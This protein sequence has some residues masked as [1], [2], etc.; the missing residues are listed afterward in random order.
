MRMIRRRYR[1]RRPRR[2]LPVWAIVAIVAGAV[3]IAALVTG[4]ILNSCLDDDTYK[5]LTDGETD[6]KEPEEEP[7]TR[8]SPSVH[9]YPFRLGESL[10]GLGTEPPQALI[11]PLKDADGRMCY[12]SP[13]TDYLGL[14][15]AEGA[16]SNAGASMTALTERVPYLI[17]VWQVSLP[18]DATDAVIHAA[19][20]TDAAVM[21]E[22]LSMGGS[23]LLLRGL[24][25]TEDTFEGTYAYLT[26]LREALGA[27]TVLSVAVPLSVAAGDFG[28]DVLYALSQKTSHLTLDL[29]A[30]ED[31]GTAREPETESGTE[32]E[33]TSGDPAE[34][35]PDSPL[36]RAAF[37]LSGY[38][39]RLL[40]GEA[41]TNLILSAEETIS[42]FAILPQ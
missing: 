21:R 15:T 10:R 38:R 1:P 28:V 42:D 41:Q 22:F 6:T 3:L 16:A 19:A 8:T 14:E 2:A 11:L 29:T 39:M 9:A 26:A 40:L 17:G 12:R 7:G 37:Y 35:M 31:I 5:K 4:N 34:E 27:D 20:V 13:V 18:R 24:S 30:E 23:E 33:E 36:L 25:L 32:G